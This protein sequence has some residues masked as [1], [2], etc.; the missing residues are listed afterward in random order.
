MIEN[1]PVNVVLT[2]STSGVLSTERAD[3]EE[4]LKIEINKIIKTGLAI[5]DSIAIEE[6]FED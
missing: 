6:T 4:E 5:G 1:F 3:S 2:N